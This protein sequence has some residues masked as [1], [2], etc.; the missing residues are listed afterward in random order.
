MSDLA[1]EFATNCTSGTAAKSSQHPG[2][3][4][5]TP[6]KQIIRALGG[7]WHGSAEW[8]AVRRGI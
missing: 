2:N 3:S 5:N 4:M 1:E 7:Q 8:R 6:A